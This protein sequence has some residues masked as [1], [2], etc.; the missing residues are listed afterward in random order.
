MVYLLQGIKAD[1]SF[2]PNHVLKYVLLFFLMNA[3]PQKMNILILFDL[4]FYVWFKG[5]LSLQMS[6]IVKFIIMI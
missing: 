4:N 2:T 6:V 1:I 5:D 3:Y